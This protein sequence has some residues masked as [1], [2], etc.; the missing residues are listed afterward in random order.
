MIHTKD[1]LRPHPT[2]PTYPPYHKGEYLEDYFYKRFSTE[3]PKVQREY[4]ALSWTTLYVQ[5]QKDEIQP[6]LDSLDQNKKYFTVLQHDDAPL[7]TLPDDT[8]CFGA[9][10]NYQGKNVIP[11]PLVCSP[12]NIEYEEN[13]RLLLASFVGSNTHPIRIKMAMHFANR[14]NCGMYLKDWSPSVQ[15]NDF[16]M[17]IDVALRSKYFLCPR[18]YGLNSFRLYECLQLG[19]V[20]VV[21]TDKFYLPWMDELNWSDFAVLIPE[22]DIGMAYNRLASIPQNMYERLKETG[23]R[24]YKDY[25]SMDGVYNNIVKRL[26]KEIK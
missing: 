22:C 4:I 16:N 2:Y 14:D 10:G 21:I 17:F 26:Q 3:L 8:L 6:F 12:L 18:G 9:G 7:N 19:C 5:N 23:K 1:S 11:I 25:F 24:V 15:S 13:E 20:P